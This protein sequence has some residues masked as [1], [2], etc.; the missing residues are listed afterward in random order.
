MPYICDLH[1]HSKYSRATSKDM[2]IEHLSKW[3]GIKGIGLLGTSD[4]TH[5][6]WLKELKERLVEK[7][8]G[9]Y[10][11]GGI[12]YILTAEVSNIYF[13]NGKVRKVHNVVIAPSFSVVTEVDRMLSEY[14]TLE[15]DGRPILSLECDKMAKAL[16]KISGDIM[17][18][19]AHIWTPHFGLFGSNSGFDT[20]E[21]CFEGEAKSITA[22][23]TG[24]SSDPAMN[25]RLSALDKYAL[26]SNSDAHSPSRIGREANVFDK[27]VGYREL[28]EVLEKKDKD[29]FMY[30][31]EFF[32]QE[33]KY[34]WDGHRK[35]EARLSPKESANVNYRCPNCGRK[36]T[37]GVMN[38]VEKLAD[39]PEGFVLNTAPGYK[40]LVPLIEIVADSMGIGRESVGAGREYNS[41]LQKLGSEF[42]ILLFKTKEEL[43]EKCPPKIAKGII[44]VRN[45]NVKILP[46][47]DGVYGKIEIFDKE[48]TKQ[49]RQ[50]TFF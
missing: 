9:I 41:L 1:I 30:T 28:K 44:N 22:L 5:P 7:E 18:I 12:D 48:D 16:K 6:A 21:E 20:I 11:H 3:A 49:E 40:N 34:H 45:G 13:K 32:P 27:R 26:V 43:L 31:V 23:E 10:T 50:L 15:S 37:V 8:Y 33:G 19:P 42:D 24:L 36:L 17:I 47:Y 2:D 35:C 4:F 29:R 39:R 46:G 25:W 38:R 14:G